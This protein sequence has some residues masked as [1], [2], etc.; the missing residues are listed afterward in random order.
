MCEPILWY[1]RNELFEK[2]IYNSLSFIIYRCILNT[3]IYIKYMYTRTKSNRSHFIHHCRCSL[4]AVVHHVHDVSC[5]QAHLC[6]LCHTRDVVN[7]HIVFFMLLLPSFRIFFPSVFH[8]LVLLSLLSCFF[9]SLLPAAPMT[10]A[11]SN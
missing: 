7:A 4:P 3:L 11:S 1:I 9:F 8:C 6:F 10:E 2:R 5:S